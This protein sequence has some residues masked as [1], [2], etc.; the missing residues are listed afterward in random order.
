MSQPL[1]IVFSLSFCSC[2]RLTGS[3]FYYYVLI[4]M[5][6][7]STGHVQVNNRPMSSLRIYAFT[8]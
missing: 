8:A 2:D 7:Q 5:I 1:L 3:K 4:V 6:K